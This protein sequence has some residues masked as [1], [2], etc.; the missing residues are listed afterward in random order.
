MTRRPRHPA[1]S[2]EDLLDLVEGRLPLERIQEL[3]PHLRADPD[4]AARVKAMSHDRAHLRTMAKGTYSAPPGLIE[5]AIAQAERDALMDDR[6]VA[7]AAGGAALMP[8]LIAGLA[9]G[10]GITLTVALAANFVMSGRSAEDTEQ[11]AHEPRESLDVPAVTLEPSTDSTPTPIVGRDQ[12]ASSGADLTPI[13]AD[14]RAVETTE[15]LTVA[16]LTSQELDRAERFARDCRLRLVI[17]S[18]DE[19]VSLASLEDLQSLRA[20]DGR[21]VVRPFDLAMFGLSDGPAG[22]PLETDHAIY[23]NE[24]SQGSYTAESEISGD[25]GVRALIRSLEDAGHEVR[26]ERAPKQRRPRTREADVIWW[27]PS[28]VDVPAARAL[29]EIIVREDV[30]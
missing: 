29:I 3:E 30:S 14:T 28:S 23:A 9:A 16:R 5:G 13:E 11:F 19:P 8:K 27:T 6:P 15:P 4:L 2:E 7:R 12:L 24:L 25:A 21:M 26:I 1:I 18:A 17:N 22:E 20:R 10:I